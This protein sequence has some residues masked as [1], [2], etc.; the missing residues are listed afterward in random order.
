M[1]FTCLLLFFVFPILIGGSFEFWKLAE[2][3][4]PTFC[5]STPCAVQIS[6]KFT[7]HGLWPSN[8]TNP[9]PEFCPSNKFDSNKIKQNLKSQLETNWPALK[10]GRN[11]SFWTYEW[12][13]HGSCSQLPQNDFLNLALSMFFKK[14]LKATLQKHRIVP[15]KRYQTASITTTIYNDIR[16]M[17]EVVCN[18]NNQLTEIRLCLNTSTNGFINCTTQAAGQ[19]SK[20]KTSVDYI[21]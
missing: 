12:D 6:S 5:R 1:K 14:D 4:P 9:Q 3:W 2:T 11:V 16:A 19:G 17:P 21:L 13:K 20:C 15:G 7:I 18:S 10:D 8:N